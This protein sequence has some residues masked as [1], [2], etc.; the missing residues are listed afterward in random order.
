[1]R[2]SASDAL[3]GQLYNVLFETSANMRE[4]QLKHRRSALRDSRRG[5]R[6]TRNIATNSKSVTARV[7]QLKHRRSALRDS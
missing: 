3:T 7:E 1:M 2:R 6:T 4:E 5:A